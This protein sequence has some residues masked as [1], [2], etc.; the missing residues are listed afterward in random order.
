MFSS[1]RCM[2]LGPVT[3]K[4]NIHFQAFSPE[5][6]TEHV[7]N[8]GNASEAYLVPCHVE[9]PRAIGRKHVPLPVGRVPAHA[10]WLAGQESHR[11]RHRFALCPGSHTPIR[12]VPCAA[13]TEPTQVVVVMCRGQLPWA[14][15]LVG[16]VPLAARSRWSPT[17][18]SGSTRQFVLARLEPR[19]WQNAKFCEPSRVLRLTGDCNAA[20][21]QPPSLACRHS[22]AT[23][24]PLRL[25][26]APSSPLS[27]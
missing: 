22:T 15:R 23:A 13:P 12:A 10:M 27:L 8:D 11:E 3:R 5:S 9:N 18:A 19:V 25:A 14:H 16:V 26:A 4:K 1:S 21:R 17:K 24:V 7:R 20:S 2:S 6:S